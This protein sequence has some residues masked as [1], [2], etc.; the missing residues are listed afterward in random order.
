M[1]DWPLAVRLAIAATAIVLAYLVQIPLEREVPGE[2]F[3]LFALAVICS[4]LAFGSG[5][6]FTA[7]GL[8]TLLSVAFF[9]PLGSVVVLTRAWDLAKIE[10]YALLSCGCVV[11]FARLRQ[12]LIAI[13]EKRR[14]CNDR[15]RTNRCCLERRRMPWRTISRRSLPSSA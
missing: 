12:T 9:E 1:Q 10:L 4:T 14:R 3:L 5:A 8:S 15:T 2:P 7:V 6:G 11:A 13:S